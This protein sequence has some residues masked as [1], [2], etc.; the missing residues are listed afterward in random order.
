M[1]RDGE[2]REVLL[3]HLS[4]ENNFPEMAYQTVKNLLEEHSLYIGKH[5]NLHIMMRDGMSPVFTLGE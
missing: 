3:A 2:Y 5:L 4:K 1:R